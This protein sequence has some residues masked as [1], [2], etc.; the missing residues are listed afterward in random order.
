MVSVQGCGLGFGVLQTGSS[1]TASL[2]RH[3]ILRV[4]LCLVRSPLKQLGNMTGLSRRFTIIL[5]RSYHPEH[6]N[7][8]YMELMS[9]GLV[10]GGPA[11]LR[12]Q[13]QVRS[14]SLKV[15]LGFCNK[16][17]DK[18]ASGKGTLG[19]ARSLI[20]KPGTLAPTHPRPSHCGL[21]H[22]RPWFISSRHM[23]TDTSF[24]CNSGNSTPSCNFAGPVEDP[25]TTLEQ[26][27]GLPSSK[28]MSSSASVQGLMILLW[29]YLV[30]TFERIVWSPWKV[31]ELLLHPLVVCPQAKGGM[32]FSADS[33]E[34]APS[35]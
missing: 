22:E 7:E 5:P 8:A 12:F 34:S 18:G 13:F 33:T 28:H 31:R 24:G 35:N 21:Q 26:H 19:I 27:E 25:S 10:A 29:W 17:L 32:F 14:L 2:R 3:K 15:G 4:P 1:Y 20:A 30:F 16:C 9:T 11:S 6:F 23:I